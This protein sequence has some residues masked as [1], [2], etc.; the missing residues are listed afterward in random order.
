MATWD[1]GKIQYV[2]QFKIIFLSRGNR[3]L[4]NFEAS[5]GGV[6]GT[7]ADPK[8]IFGAAFKCNSS[9]I[10]LAPKH[11]LAALKPSQ[12][13]IGMTRKLVWA[14]QLLDMPILDHVI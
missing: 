14:G 6:S 7:V 11:P 12:A 9:S 4:G 5:S 3:V 8:L 10:V 1:Q 2:E 13:D